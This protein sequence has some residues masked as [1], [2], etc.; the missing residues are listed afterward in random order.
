MLLSIQDLK[1]AFRM[2]RTGGVMQRRRTARIFALNH[3]RAGG[4]LD[5]DLAA[6]PGAH[7][8]D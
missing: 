5:L 8:G 7:G 3:I 4:D 2:G 6:I 1:V